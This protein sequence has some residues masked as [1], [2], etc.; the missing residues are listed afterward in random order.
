MLRR[1]NGHVL[2]RENG[3]VMRS[4]LDFEAEE[5]DAEEGMEEAG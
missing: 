1:E 5:S 3:H 4:T 2:R